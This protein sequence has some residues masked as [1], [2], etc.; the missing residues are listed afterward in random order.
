[1]G[2][3]SNGWHLRYLLV[4]T[5]LITDSLRFVLSRDS[6]SNQRLLFNDGFY[7]QFQDLSNLQCSIRCSLKALPIVIFQQSLKALPIIISLIITLVLNVNKTVFYVLLVTLFPEVGPWHYGRFL[8][9]L[10]ESGS[11][12]VAFTLA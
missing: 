7:F 2:K 5:D 6:V 10:P 3:P 4:F 11:I 8:G 9:G 12:L 1:M